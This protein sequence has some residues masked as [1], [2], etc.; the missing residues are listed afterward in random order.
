VIQ[1]RPYQDKCIAGLRGAFS[2]GF[3]SPLLV[4]PTGSGK[5]CMF[6]Y[7][8]SRLLESRKRVVI[9]AHREELLDQISRTL[10][11][12]NVRHGMIAA[13]ALYDRRLLAHVAS[14]QTLARRLERVAVPDYAIID[15][16]HHAVAASMYGKII[17][18]WRQ[19]NP[20]LRVIGVTATPERL[21]GEGLGETFDEMI[22]G[23]TTREL[24]DLGALSDYRLFAPKVA[25][26]L[27]AVSVRAGDYAKGELGAAL[28]KPAIIGSAV[29]EYRKLC[30]GLP[31]VAFCV[32]IEHAAH[33]AEQFRAAGYRSASIDGKMDKA[34]R[35]QVVQDFGAGR[36]NV[37][38]SCDLINEG[39]DVPGIV[40][41]ILLRP[42]QSLALYLQQVGRALR[43]APGQD[44]AIIL[45]HVLN[46]NR[47][48]LPDDPREWSLIGRDAKRKSATDNVACRQCLPYEVRPGMTVGGCY[49]VSPASAAKCRECGVP[50]QVKARTVEEV[51]GTL[52]EVEVARM[53]RQAAREQAAAQTLED[54]IALGAARGFKN[55]AGW[56]RHVYAAREAK[57]AAS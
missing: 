34:E 1:L 15:E 51:E 39:F 10:S 56:A 7:L 26:D 53:R 32:S 57:R 6:S 20:N 37:L 11:D 5:T 18:R 45:D 9:M 43:T 24:I 27:S 29:G 54:L 40:V 21:S 31:A 16:A 8:T 12:F 28:D 30:D 38:T 48:G 2:A 36:L 41:A 47:H 22:L 23:P 46:A 4:S 19:A 25:V 42:T 35:R 44:A 33:T 52:S 55:P 49:A 50:F 3:H 14:V 17:A 13:H